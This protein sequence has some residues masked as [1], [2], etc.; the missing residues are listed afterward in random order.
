MLRR[1]FINPLLTFSQRIDQRVTSRRAVT[2]T[3]TEKDVTS[4]VILA[5]LLILAEIAVRKRE[6]NIERTEKANAAHTNL[7]GQTTVVLLR[8]TVVLGLD[9]GHLSWT[10]RLALLDDAIAEL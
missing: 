1:I 3:E 8:I 4:T 6:E 2:E 10:L 7:K 9:P 5:I